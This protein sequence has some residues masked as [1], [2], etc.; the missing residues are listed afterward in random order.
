MKFGSVCS[1]IEAASVAWQGLGWNPA[2]FSEIEPFPC[3]L[4]KQHYPQTPNFGDMTKFESWSDD[5]KYAIDL[6]CGGTPC[7]SF[8]V[9][10]L[11]TGLSDPRGNLM[12]TFAAIAA[13]YRPK[14]VVWENVPG[15]LSSEKGYDF[16]EFL[17]LLSGQGIEPP[18]DGWGNSG[19]IVGYKNA[20][21]IAWRVL[22]AQ[23]FGVAQRRRRVFVVGCLGDW[24][25]ATSVLFEQYSLSG[26]PAP[27]RQ[28]GEEVAARFGP[29]VASGKKNIGTLMANAGSKMWLGNQEALSGDY[30]ILQPMAFST[31]DYG[32]DAQI[33]LSPTLLNQ[34]TGIGIAYALAGNTIGRS[35]ENGGNG[36][37]YSE[38]VGYTQT[39]TDQHAVVFQSKV[40]RLMPIE[41]ERLQ[42]FPDNYT[43]ITHKGKPAADSPRYKALG[44]SWAVPVVKWIGERIMQV[45]QTNLAVQQYR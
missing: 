24:R 31:K 21:S 19:I 10:G 15:V 36:V 41:C 34:H 42:G 17:G 27:S 11:R 40:R 4:L 29:C 45:E 3:S 13:K 43:L 28:T 1:G 22:D 18:A 44:N 16:A 35:P 20:Y 2:W 12:L 32:N 30:H 23:Y 8:S 7:Q 25:S 33:N 37:G 5:E 26:Y 6:L 14:W 38:E 39:K 9:A